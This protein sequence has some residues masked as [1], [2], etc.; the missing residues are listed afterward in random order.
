M[1]QRLDLAQSVAVRRLDPTAL[2]YAARALRDFGDV[3]RFNELLVWVFPNPWQRN[4]PVDLLLC[5]TIA[6]IVVRFRH[7]WQR[8]A[9]WVLGAALILSPVL[10]PWY[11]TWILPLAIWRRRSQGWASTPSWEP[12]STRTPPPSKP[13]TTTLRASPPGST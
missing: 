11:A 2:I 6:V 4:W 9:L 1:Q 13:P 12:T 10:H 8:S 3:T 5:A 7:D